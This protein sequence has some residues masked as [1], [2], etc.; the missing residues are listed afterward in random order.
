MSEHLC[1]AE[2]CETPVPPAKLMCLKH[3]RLVPREIQCRVWRHYRPGQEVDKRPSQEYLQVMR[4]AIAA[5]AQ[6]DG[7]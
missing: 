3:W 2:G 7:R 1:H 6:R 5:V 4:E